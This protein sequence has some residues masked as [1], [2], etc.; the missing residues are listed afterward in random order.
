MIAPNLSESKSVGKLL[1]GSESDERLDDVESYVP[2]WIVVGESV[3]IR[4]YN[5]SG[6]VAFLG[7]TEFASGVWVGVELDAPTGKLCLR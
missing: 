6:V 4:P 5:I 1:N 7:P 2:D 3:L